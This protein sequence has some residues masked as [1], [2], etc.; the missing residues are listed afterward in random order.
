MSDAPPI[1]SAAF[2]GAPPAQP[3]VWWRRR[4]YLVALVVAVIV[5]VT[6]LTDLPQGAS[7]SVQY[8]TDLG[9]M[10]SVNSS[11]SGCS[12]AVKESFMIHRRQLAGSLT[13]FDKA[14]VPKLLQDDQMACSF[15]SQP[16]FDLSNVEVPS[17]TSGR[18]LARMVGTV[19]TWATS[20][21]LAAIEAIQKLWV[22]PQEAS[23]LRQLAKAQRLM[24]SDRTLSE[25]D[26]SSADQIVQNRLPKLRL[27][28]E[29]A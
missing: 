13:A 22:H 18:Y 24:A 6:V 11:I 16:I 9:V 1:E 28:S 17:S 29:P 14:Q 10:S 8:R 19:T 25:G 3:R 23:A 27:T 5:V 2:E 21:C 15:T 4:S 26:V 20:D 12:Y 7:P